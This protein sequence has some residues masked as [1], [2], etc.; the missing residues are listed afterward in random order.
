MAVEM[1]QELKNYICAYLSAWR[2]GAEE[3]GGELPPDWEF[4]V[5]NGLYAPEKFYADFLEA[6]GMSQLPDLLRVMD[7][8][9]E[10]RRSIFLTD[11]DPRRLPFPAAFQAAFVKVAEKDA[12]SDDVAKRQLVRMVFE[13]LQSLGMTRIR[14]S[15]VSKDYHVLPIAGWLS[16][17]EHTDKEEFLQKSQESRQ[18]VFDNECTIAYAK[19]WI[20]IHFEMEDWPYSPSDERYKVEEYFSDWMHTL[21]VCNSSSCVYTRC[22][23]TTDIKWLPYL[24]AYIYINDPHRARKYVSTDLERA[25]AKFCRHYANEP[26]KPEN[27]QSL[28]KALR[29]LKEYYGMQILD[30]RES[31]SEPSF[32]RMICSGIWR[33]PLE[34]YAR[35][36]MPFSEFDVES[37]SK[38]F[39]EFY[40]NARKNARETGE[41]LKNE[42]E[43]A[44]LQDMQV[45]RFHAGW[46]VYKRI[47]NIGDSLGASGYWRP[48]CVNTPSLFA[49]PSKVHNVFLSLSAG[50]FVVA[51]I[52]AIMHRTELI[53]DHWMW[54]GIFLVS[55]LC[56]FLFRELRVFLSCCAY[57]AVINRENWEK[58]EVSYLEECQKEYC[59]NSY[60]GR[61]IEG[62]RFRWAVHC[63]VVMSR[64]VGWIGSILE[65]Y[66][67]KSMLDEII[68][69]SFSAQRA[70]FRNALPHKGKQW[71]LPPKKP[72]K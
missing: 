8:L 57:A 30:E 32:S 39:D 44:P 34:E 14:Q 13:T 7:R 23:E 46:E 20:D 37:W 1:T 40:D 10:H 71:P 17:F 62:P 26:Q 65:A 54:I 9:Q 5:K 25:L 63:S 61:T 45:D 2:N 24:L 38:T 22:L 58:D 43:Q 27:Y 72:V 59:L 42:A 52:Y 16:F 49:H 53:A 6:N 48:W 21:R 41:P 47:R 31:L 29:I 18:R 64:L 36:G 69:I 66:G 28:A 33:P 4:Y 35:V 55:S 70:L 68:G 12:V 11:G 3:C 67:D 56:A 60:G 51:L 50:A 15:V 19:S